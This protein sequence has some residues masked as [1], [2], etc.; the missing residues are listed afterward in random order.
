MS[1]EAPINPIAD[2][3]I[4]LNKRI[5]LVNERLL[6]QQQHFSRLAEIQQNTILAL[7]DRIK[8]LEG[9]P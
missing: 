5:N 1:L 9:H 4:S 2:T 3:I 8:R 6:E 7:E